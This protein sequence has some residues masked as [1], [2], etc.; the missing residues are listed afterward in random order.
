MPK[1]YLTA[2]FPAKATEML[3]AAGLTVD[4]YQGDGLISKNE[5]LTA[6]ADVDFLITALSTKVDADIINAAPKL[7]LI[8]NYGAGFN[9]IDI[10]TAREHNIPVTNTPVVSTISTAEVTVG[11]I[12][13]V[14]H[15]M[16]EGDQLMRNEGFAGWAPLFFLGHELHGKT[17]G[18]VGMGSIGQAVAKRLKA[19]DT[20]I[21]YTQRHQLDAVTEAELGARFVELPELLASSDIITLHVPM[22]DELHHLINA[23]TL[24]QMKPSAYLINAA[25]GPVIDETAVLAALQ[26][27][28]LAG[29]GLDVYEAEPAVADGFKQ[30]KNVVLTPHIGNATVEAR[31]AMA[32][33][34]AQNAI[35]VSQGAE[36]EHVVNN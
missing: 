32:E 12:L 17:V 1:V 28:K 9:N 35:L 6:V 4:S 31:D 3:T 18:I 14:M 15:R 10:T 8:A 25:R 36:P 16:A 33:I 27:G 34:V 13:S 22:T 30:L 5:L 26:N 21:I 7:K 20:E 24:Q 11:L 29:A 2:E 19:F 23:K